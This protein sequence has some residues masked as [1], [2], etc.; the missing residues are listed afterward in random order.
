MHQFKYEKLNQQRVVDLIKDSKDD[1]IDDI[2]LLRRSNSTCNKQNKTDS[3]QFGFNNQTM[4]T[5][6]NQTNTPFVV[7]III[8]FYVY[9]QP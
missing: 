8:K 1:D 9:Q 2:W 6:P 3:R 4:Q 5:K 7:V